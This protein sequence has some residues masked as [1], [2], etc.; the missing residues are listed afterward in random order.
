VSERKPP[1]PGASGACSP[2]SA[3]G[4]W[5]RLETRRTTLPE[6]PGRRWT[7]WGIDFRR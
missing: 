3:A 2:L 5:R 7:A 1:F 6:R 4:A